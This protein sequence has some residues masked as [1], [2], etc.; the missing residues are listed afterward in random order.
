M[1]R[2]ALNTASIPLVRRL[3]VEHLRQHPRWLILA[4]L[5]TLGVAGST[6]LYPII[7]QQ[8]FNRFAEGDPRVAWLLPP[9]IIAVTCTKAIATYGQ[10]VAT[11]NVVYRTI[12]G[13]QRRLFSA[14]TRADLAVASREAPARQAARFTTDAGMIRE[15]LGKSISGVADTLTVIG[16]VGS[17]LWMDWQMALLGALLYP[18]AAWPILAIGKRIRRASSGMQDRVGETSA[19]LV[20]SLG[21]A[22]VVRA[23]RLEAQEEARADTAFARLRDSL[24]GIARTRARLDPVLEALGGLAVAAVLGFVGWRV[25]N[26]MGTIGDFTGFVAALL[27]ASRPVRSL[28]SLNAALQEGLAGLSRTFVAVDEPRHILDR[29]GA[30][31]LPPGQGSIAFEGVGFRYDGISDAALGGLSFAAAPGRTVALVGPSGAG[32]STALALVP[33]LYDVTE[34][35]I[36][37]DGADLRAV[38]LA[39]LRDAIAYVGQDAVLFDDTAFANIACGKPGA[40]LAEVQE[41]ARAAAAHDF[42]ETLPQG[43]DTPLGNAGSRLSGGQ[44]QRVS[45]ARALLRNPRVLL[46]DEATS[47]L[48]AENEA[49]VQQ[50]L[51]RLRAGRTTLV[52]A[53]R[54]STVRDA[55]LIVVMEGGRAVEQGTHAELMTQDGLYARL[56]RTQAFSA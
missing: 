1:A 2:P 31:A 22:R 41:A 18:I 12:E 15:A 50:A 24:L 10:A 49:L 33:R 25:A 34:G 35:R 54:L 5:C 47:A 26:G 40:T 3:W 30:I 20:E 43:Y 45:L 27:I 19:L 38:T 55:D 32:K 44:R 23:Y 51:A 39:S 52:I 8:A 21:A 46:L 36:T 56:V 48:D 4:A 37:L 7:I 9:I 53:H 11:Q 13:L 42:L 14:L 16:L 28:G 17:M 6:A 29:E